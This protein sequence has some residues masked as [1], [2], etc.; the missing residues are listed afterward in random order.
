MR[1]RPNGSQ[2]LERHQLPKANPIHGTHE[3]GNKDNKPRRLKP[4]FRILILLATA[5]VPF[6]CLHDYYS[7]SQRFS[8]WLFLLLTLI[9]TAYQFWFWTVMYHDLYG[10]S[11][12]G[13]AK[14]TQGE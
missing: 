1:N 10:E 11:W 5:G 2:L 3:A 8:V 14:T 4:L 12:W 7:V 6:I 13:T 9:T